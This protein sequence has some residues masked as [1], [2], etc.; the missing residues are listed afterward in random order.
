[1]ILN[2]LT[3]CLYHLR[4]GTMALHH[5][6]WFVQYLGLIREPCTCQASTLSTELHPQPLGVHCERWNNINCMLVIWVVCLCRNVWSFYCRAFYIYIL[7]LT[8]M[9]KLWNPGEK[10]QA[11]FFLPPLKL[12]LVSIFAVA[13]LSFFHAQNSFTS[14]VRFISHSS[15][16]LYRQSLNCN[17][18]PYCIP[19]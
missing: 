13:P 15:V 11:W 17:S 10:Q 6:G 4:P 18:F 3:S 9:E 7:S 12:C 5:H 2:F 16:D 19:Y 14:L 1:M 8:S